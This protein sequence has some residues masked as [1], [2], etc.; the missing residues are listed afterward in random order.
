MAVIKHWRGRE[1]KTRQMAYFDE[2][3]KLGMKNRERWFWGIFG[4]EAPGR[5]KKRR[6]S[7]SRIASSRQE[8]NLGRKMTPFSTSH[9][10]FP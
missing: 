10:A 6:A 7:S 3:Q 4:K 1:D 2:R 5:R 9:L 8:Q